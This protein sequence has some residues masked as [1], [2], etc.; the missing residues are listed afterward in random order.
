VDSAATSSR[1]ESGG[2]LDGRSSSAVVLSST[3]TQR[4]WRRSRVDSR[5]T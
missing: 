4:V 5:T 1:V 2:E 3:D